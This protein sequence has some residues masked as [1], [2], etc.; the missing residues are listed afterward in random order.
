M[1]IVYYL[2]PQ[3]SIHFTT[4]IKINGNKTVPIGNYYKT[5]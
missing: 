3:I 2:L 4:N 1:A 5:L